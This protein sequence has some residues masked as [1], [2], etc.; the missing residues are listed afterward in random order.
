[1]GCAI[2]TRLQ[3]GQ[4]YTTTDLRI[5]YLRALTDK[6]RPGAEGRW[7]TSAARRR[8][9]RAGCTMSTTVSTPSAR[10]PAWSCTW[11]D[12]RGFARKAA[13]R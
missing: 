1:M 8:S 9:P 2:H 5:S 11:P 7:C 10:P 13:R 6:G 4:G 3:A 12:E